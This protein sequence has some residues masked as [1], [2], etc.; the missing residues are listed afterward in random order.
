MQWNIKNLSFTGSWNQVCDLSW[1]TVGFGWIQVP[2][3]GL[4]SQS[5]M[6]GFRMCISS[7]TWL[8]LTLELSPAAS[9]R[10]PLDIYLRNLP[11]TWDMTILSCAISP[12][13][14]YKGYDINKFAS[15]LSLC[16]L[17]KSFWDKLCSFSWKTVFESHRGAG[18]LRLHHRHKTK[19][20]SFFDHSPRWLS[21]KESACQCRRHKRCGFNLWVGLIPGEG[22][23]YPLQ[24]SCLEN[25]MNRGPW[26]IGSR[27]EKS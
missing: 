18:P 27:V 24:Y 7:F 11:K 22:N 19:S 12:Q 13:P 9:Q 23:G 26:V 10:P 17:L 14:L 6:K 3:H 25:S 1:K 8:W 16:L 4:K 20:G 5:E 15:Y 2:A 21:G